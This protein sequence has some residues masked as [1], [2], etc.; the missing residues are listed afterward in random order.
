LCRAPD[1]LRGIQTCRDGTR[2]DFSS[3]QLRFVTAA[4]SPP[5]CGG[6]PT[7]PRCGVAPDASV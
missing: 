5:E 3:G 2:P 7:D 1:A 4:V 6:R